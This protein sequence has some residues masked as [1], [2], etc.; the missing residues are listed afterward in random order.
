MRTFFN[1][2]MALVLLASIA[3]LINRN[4]DYAILHSHGNS[5]DIGDIRPLLEGLKNHG[6]SVFAYGYRLLHEGISVD[7]NNWTV[8]RG[9]CF[10]NVIYRGWHFRNFIR[11]GRC[12]YSAPIDI[13]SFSLLN[14]RGSLNYC[15]PKTLQGRMA[16]FHRDFDY[17]FRDLFFQY[18]I[19]IFIG[20]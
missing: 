13:F 12:Y 8:N 11:V 9:K 14:W 6:F 1:C 15:R 20:A 10:E 17:I 3:V 2:E 18:W 19:R 5:E 16:N 4:S 7:R